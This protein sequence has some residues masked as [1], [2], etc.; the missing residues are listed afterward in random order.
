MQY[1]ENLNLR[2]ALLKAAREI[3][4]G[5]FLLYKSLSVQNEK[6]SVYAGFGVFG[7]FKAIKLVQIDFPYIEA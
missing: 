2:R 6:P 5:V 7:L 1:L 3:L 4:V